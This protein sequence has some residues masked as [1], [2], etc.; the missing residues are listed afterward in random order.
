MNFIQ[1]LSNL[2][3]HWPDVP[4][5]VFYDVFD[6]GD[7][8]ISAHRQEPYDLILLDVVMPM[9][10]GIETA[11][12]IR[13]TDRCVKIVF[14]SSSPEYALDSYT[15]RADH[16]LLKATLS[17][18]LYSGLNDILFNTLTTPPENSLT[19]KGLNAVYNIPLHQIEY[20][21]AQNKHIVLF[22]H[23]GSV[24]ETTEPLRHFEEVLKGKDGFFKCHRSY[25]VNLFHIDSY[26]QKEIKMQSGARI[27]ISRNC[28][29][30]FEEAYFNLYFRRAGD[31]R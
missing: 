27:P 11:R 6:D 28:H 5:P 10:N 12:E 23:D 26:T 21:E 2:L 14:L 13:L 24:K 29:R 8:L 4:Q 31:I 20:L 7:S 18:T 30:D 19:I 1:E 17:D 16:Y 3:E 9:L 15:V 25:I 22:L